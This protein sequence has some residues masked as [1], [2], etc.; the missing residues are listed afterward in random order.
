[1]EI[2]ENITIIGGV[3]KYGVGE[4]ISEIVVSKGEIIG[5]V[6]PIIATV[7]ALPQ[8]GSIP[9]IVLF[10]KEVP[11]MITTSH[12]GKS[13]GSAQSGLYSLSPSMG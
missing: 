5:V 13:R 11:L 10:M 1:M 8:R 7:L 3:D 12:L 9:S 2:I 6:G 4:P